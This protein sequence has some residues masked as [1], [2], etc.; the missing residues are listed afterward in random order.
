MDSEEARNFHEIKPGPTLR[1]TSLHEM[2]LCKRW[3]GVSYFSFFLVPPI[4]LSLLHCC[5]PSP[6]LHICYS[7]AHRQ[8][9][10]GKNS[11]HSSKIFGGCPITSYATL[12]LFALKICCNR[13]ILTFV[14]YVVLSFAGKATCHDMQ[15]HML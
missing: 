3:G 15:R 1:K 5:S 10:E 2:I 9:G 4:P 14:K 8:H 7:K 12:L 6:S 13:K 11:R